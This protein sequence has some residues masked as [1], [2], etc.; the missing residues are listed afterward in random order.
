M[1]KEEPMK[2]KN[3]RRGATLTEIM[4]VIA[5]VAIVAVLV[6]SFS[7]MVSSSRELAQA[8]LDALQDIRLAE[9]IIENFIVDSANKGEVD[10]DSIYF[11]GGYLVINRGEINNNTVLQLESVTGIRFDILEKENDTIYYC[12]IS[13]EVGGTPFEYTFCVN[14]YAGEEIGG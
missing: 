11:N 7:T 2:T 5:V 8:K 14:P 12:T 13:Y 6:V 9:T 3:L 1:R 10:T 4:V